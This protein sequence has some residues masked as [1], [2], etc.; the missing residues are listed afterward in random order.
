M[1]RHQVS[2]THG[3]KWQLARTTGV[4]HGPFALFILGS[5]Y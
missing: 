3:Q 4:R 5:P 1:L 2:P